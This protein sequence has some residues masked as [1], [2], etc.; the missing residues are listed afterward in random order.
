MFYFCLRT[1]LSGFWCASISCCLKSKCFPVASFNINVSQVR[2]SNIFCN[3]GDIKIGP[4]IKPF[5]LLIAKRL[6]IGRLV[7]AQSYERTPF[8][9]ASVVVRKWMT[10][11][12]VIRSRRSTDKWLTDSFFKFF[13]L[14]RA[15]PSYVNMKNQIKYNGNRERW[16]G[17]STSNGKMKNGS[18]KR[19]GNES[20]AS[21]L[22]FVPFFHFSR[23][24]VLVPRF[25]NIQI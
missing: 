9:Q 25:S 20:L 7:K 19:T 3:S 24:P 12:G 15:I 13:R 8:P 22:D 14:Q 18:K 4:P 23:S 16:A 17:K 5:K 21:K 11:H 10:F 6:P 1:P 2:D